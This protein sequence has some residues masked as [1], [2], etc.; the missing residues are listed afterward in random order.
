MDFL[1]SSPSDRTHHTR[2]TSSSQNEASAELGSHYVSRLPGLLNSRSLPGQAS[3]F[4]NRSTGQFLRPVGLPSSMRED[5]RLA[6]LLSSVPRPNQE[7]FINPW[8]GSSVR[9]ASYQNPDQVT[10]EPLPLKEAKI[11]SESSEYSKSAVEQWIQKMVEKEPWFW[12]RTALFK[13]KRI[14]AKKRKLQ[15]ETREKA[16][17]TR[18]LACIVKSR[19]QEPEQQEMYVNLSYVVKMP[20]KET[21]DTNPFLDKKRKIPF[22][23]TKRKVHSK[24]WIE[25]AAEFRVLVEGTKRTDKSK[26]RILEWFKQVWKTKD[27]LWDKASVCRRMVALINHLHTRNNWERKTIFDILEEGSYDCLDRTAVALDS[28]EIE[29]LCQRARD[30]GDSDKEE[31]ALVSLGLCAFV[32]SIISHDIKKFLTKEEIDKDK[33]EDPLEDF[34]HHALLLSTVIDFGFHAT[35]MHFDHYAL[36]RKIE[37]IISILFD[38]FTEER[39]CHFFSLWPHWLAYTGKQTEQ[40]FNLEIMKELNEEMKDPLA[41]ESLYQAIF[42]ETKME[43]KVSRRDEVSDSVL[44]GKLLEKR[45]REKMQANEE[46]LHLR[47]LKALKNHG[48]LTRN[49]Y[50][51]LPEGWSNDL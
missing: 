45:K 27:A 38:A 44:Y 35:G 51:D 40:A 46:A 26:E 42:E 39:L 22:T 11:A 10:P 12:E 1:A 48:I 5:C 3:P 4:F 18:G 49:I 34:F 9:S 14:Y 29:M 31:K 36:K 47:T 33:K 6:G 32:R 17:M 25:Y 24:E 19:K 21:W 30:K 20:N 43:L 28:A 50:Y 23:S 16:S 37:E 13:L 8:T 15:I 7:N 41:E 2:N